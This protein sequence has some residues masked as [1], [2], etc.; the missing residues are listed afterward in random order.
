MAEEHK[1]TEEHSDIFHCLKCGRLAYE[2]HG[3]IASAGLL[4]A[5]DGSGGRRRA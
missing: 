4:R 2:P 3:T 5:A 1:I